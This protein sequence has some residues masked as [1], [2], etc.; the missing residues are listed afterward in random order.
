VETDESNILRVLDDALSKAN[1]ILVAAHANP[2]G[3]AVGSMLGL[4][5]ILAEMKKEVTAY[6]PDGIPASMAFLP[7]ADN[8]R[9]AIDGSYDVTFLLDTPERALFAVGFAPQG[10]F[11][12][13]DHH[14]AFEPM[15]DIVIRKPASA[16]GELI[17]EAA[18][19]LA[20][21]VSAEA[22]LCLYTSIV[23]DT[24]SFKY[25]SATPAAHRAAAD[26]IALGADPCRVATHLFESFSAVR[27]HLLAKV[28]C[29]LETSAEG[30]F[31]VM[32]CTREMMTSVGASNDDLEGM[33]NEA[34]CIEGV[35]LAAV[36]REEADGSIRV[37]LRSK[38]G[39][40]ASVPATYFGGGGHVNAAGYR[41]C[42][43]TV[44][45]A[46]ALLKTQANQLLLGSK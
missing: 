18:V 38:G 3:D 8:A 9:T 24:S 31:A 22:A 5:H 1:R 36:M 17:F 25:N 44:T 43:G 39:I 4:C 28:L 46:V 34:R 33:V 20:W 40:D 45:Q 13:V 21:P 15:G 7:G 10:I 14:N 37:S 6:C 12:V 26:L 23:A 19:K 41:F 2:D 11:V 42:D 32:Y 27:R 30:K 35:E 16:V 29:T